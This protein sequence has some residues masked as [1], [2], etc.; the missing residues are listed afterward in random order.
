LVSDRKAVTAA[1][2]ETRDAF[3]MDFVI[4]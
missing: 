1:V 3:F 4:G 2:I